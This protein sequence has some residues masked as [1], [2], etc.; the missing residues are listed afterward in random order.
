MHGRNI[1]FN[2]RKFLLFQLTINFVVIVVVFSGSVIK[3]DSP[4]NVVQLLWLNLVMDAFG[5]LALATE[6]PTREVLDTKPIKEEEPIM[7]AQMW[8]QILGMGL[9]QILCL[10]ALVC[11]FS[12][13]MGVYEYNGYKCGARDVLF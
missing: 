9:Y 1:F 3:G 12:D 4:L 13:I 2:V 10:L 11:Y 8:K 6:P 5:A 7:T